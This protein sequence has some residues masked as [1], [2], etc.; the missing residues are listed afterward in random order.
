ML[1]KDIAVNTI[2]QRNNNEWWK[3]RTGRLTSSLFGR[4]ASARSEATAQRIA[5][6]IGGVVVEESKIPDACLMGIM[7]EPN[8]K[9]AYVRVMRESFNVEVRV[10]DIGLC[11]PKWAPHL[12]ASPDG[13]VYNI[14]DPTAQPWLLEVKCLY[15]TNVVPRSIAEIAGDRGSTFYCIKLSSGEYALK[16]THPYYAQILGQLAITGLQNAHLTI[17]AP[18]NGDIVIVPVSYDDCDWS[19]MRRKLDRFYYDYM[20][21]VEPM[22]TFECTSIVALTSSD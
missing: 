3:Y 10:R 21:P 8:A 16:K 9:E 20:A 14:N 12:G 4:I 22:D 11:I 1:Y 15:D 13:V 6:S 5:S 7:E 19:N 2:G 17:Y 18:R